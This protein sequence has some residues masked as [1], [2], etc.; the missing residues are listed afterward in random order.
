[1]RKDCIRKRGNVGKGKG[2]YGGGE[3]ER[4][5]TMSD[6]RKGGEGNYKRINIG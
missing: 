2:R 3:A 6:I 1:M 5:N 4:G